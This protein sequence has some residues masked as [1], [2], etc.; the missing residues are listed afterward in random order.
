MRAI[1]KVHRVEMVAM[2]GADR[3]VTEVNPGK[4]EAN[5]EEIRV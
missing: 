5:P 3:E 4:L 1:M 2:F